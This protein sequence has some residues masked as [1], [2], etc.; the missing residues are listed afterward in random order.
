MNNEELREYQEKMGSPEMERLQNLIDFPPK[1]KC[2]R[3]NDNG[4]PACDGT[5]GNKYNP[6]PY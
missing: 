1:P 5:K 3:C 2:F 6:E 4:C